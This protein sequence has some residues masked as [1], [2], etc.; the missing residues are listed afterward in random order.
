MDIDNY[1]I[2]GESFHC[3][4]DYFHCEHEFVWNDQSYEEVFTGFYECEI[5]GYVDPDR[6]YE[7]FDE[8]F[9]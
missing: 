3:E 2:F 6:E 9:D 1:D 7:Y 8:Y 5:C 4:H